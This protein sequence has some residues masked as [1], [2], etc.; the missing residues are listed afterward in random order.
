MMEKCFDISACD[1]LIDLH[2]HLDGSLSLES[3]KD[4]ARL[5][6]VELELSDGEILSR[7][8][9]GDNCRDL[10][11]YLEK[12]EFPLTLLQSEKSIDEIYNYI[13]CNLTSSRHLFV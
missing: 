13:L 12:F 3:V 11:E 6:G 9:V 1:C 8:T 10:N 5:E 2:L 7:M 4:L